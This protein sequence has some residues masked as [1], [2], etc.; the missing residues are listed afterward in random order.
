MNQRGE[1]LLLDIF[2]SQ[3]GSPIMSRIKWKDTKPQPIVRKE[4]SPSLGNC[5]RLHDKSLLSKTDI[6]L[7][8]RSAFVFVK[9]CLWRGYECHLFK[10]PKS[11]AK[12]WNTKISR[13]TRKLLENL[14]A[15]TGALSFFGGVALGEKKKQSSSQTLN[16]IAEWLDGVEKLKSIRGENG[17]SRSF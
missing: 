5:Y 10:R 12:W 6:V 11:R 14:M 3:T 2:D 7:R 15:R 13:K 8:S 1:R 4:L 17:A 9:R 16:E